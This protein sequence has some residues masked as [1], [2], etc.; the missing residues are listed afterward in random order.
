MLP[1]IR[2]KPRGAHPDST[3]APVPE[4]TES[5]AQ[6]GPKRSPIAGDPPDPAVPAPPTQRRRTSRLR[7]S[8]VTLY[9]CA[10]ERRRTATRNAAENT[11]RSERR[12][13]VEKIGALVF[14]GDDT[15]WYTMP[16]YR[17]AKK[18]FF[19]I[20]HSQGFD[21]SHVEE[22]FE[23]IDARNVKRLG[24]TGKRFRASMLQ[25]YRAF[26]KRSHRTPTRRLERQ[27]SRIASS[28][29][30]GRPAVA[31]SARTTLTQLRKHYR[32]F[33]LTKGEP[34]VQRRRIEDSG[35]KELFDGIVIVPHKE[36][37]TFSRLL[38]AHKCLPRHAWSIGNSI[39]SD[40]NT[41]IRAGLKTI[42]IPNETW[43]YEEESP[44]KDAPIRARSLREIPNILAEEG[45]T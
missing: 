28:T 34:S 13:A 11:R 36:P 16:L 5:L 4:R 32:L 29:S 8:A 1:A 43:R 3:A 9:T 41:A 2:T 23:R 7:P 10:M 39:K 27:I 31:P 24:F 26:C 40:I 37:Q 20:M 21:R 35:L 14:D 17:S 42:W 30:R 45:R 6:L 19:D 25:T 38:A 33:L 15:L 18:D 22:S 44:G 12:T